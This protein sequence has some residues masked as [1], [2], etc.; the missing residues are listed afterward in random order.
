[1]YKHQYRNEETE[2]EYSY[3]GEEEG[4]FVNHICVASE[5]RNTLTQPMRIH[6]DQQPQTSIPDQVQATHDLVRQIH[7][8]QTIPPTSLVDTNLNN[9]DSDQ[10][11]T[12]ASSTTTPPTT[13]PTDTDIIDTDTTTTTTNKQ[14]Q[15]QP[16]NR[17]ERSEQTIISIES[18]KF[19]IKLSSIILEIFQ[20][21]FINTVD[22]VDNDYKTKQAQAAARLT[23][24]KQEQ[25]DLAEK[26]QRNMENNEQGKATREICQEEIRDNEITMKNKDSNKH[27]K[28]QHNDRP[29]PP[30]IL[31]KERTQ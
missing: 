26:M 30:R 13:G 15:T 10:M 14:T 23:R 5:N 12:N 16:E 9:D 22:K 25:I 28:N 2:T 17:P 8:T 29:P 1:M 31:T 4:N 24:K 20:N 27:H 7:L 3:Q 6:E 11:H 19:C 21:V 18:Q